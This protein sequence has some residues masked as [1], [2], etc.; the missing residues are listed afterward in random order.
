MSSP[1]TH[2]ILKTI[3]PTDRA[4]DSPMITPLHDDPYMLVR[5]AYTP[6]AM[7]IE[8][9]PFEDPI[10]TEET[11][12][13]CHRAAP[14]SLDYTS[15][16]PDYTPNTLY[17]DEDS[18]PMEAYKTRTALPSDTE[19]EGDKSGA[20]GTNLESEESEDAGPGSESEE[21]VSEEQQQRAVPVKDT[22]TYK[23]FGL[24]YGAARRRALEL[25]EGLAPTSLTIPLP[26]ASPVTTLAA[27][28]AVEKDEFL[29]VGAQL[30]LHGSILHDHTQRLD[31]LLPT[32]FEGYGGDFTQLFARSEARH[33]YRREILALRMYHT[34][35][36]H[37]MQGLKERVV[38]LKR[39][40]DHV[41]R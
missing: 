29:E 23:S 31:A 40:M 10:E 35:D 13:L 33:K 7:D 4:R 12:P 24:G 28:I 30:E 1:S 37:E 14:L 11:Q 34:A 38:I 18:Q 17:S 2:T 5:Q 21:V 25:A 19:T 32:L 6:I 36:Q 27:T 8:S 41:E 20:E 3:T 15:A 16:S 39:R 22:G 9:E 26:V